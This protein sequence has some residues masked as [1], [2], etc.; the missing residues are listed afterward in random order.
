MNFDRRLAF[1]ASN[2]PPSSYQLQRHCAVQLRG[3]TDGKLQTPAWQQVL[4]RGEQNA[5]AAHVDGFP[6]THFVRVLSIENLVANFPFY[7]KT[8]RSTALIF[9]LFRSHSTPPI[10]LLPTFRLPHLL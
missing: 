5:V 7:R 4:I 3:P 6:K 8:I 2:H 1:F 10:I 9:F